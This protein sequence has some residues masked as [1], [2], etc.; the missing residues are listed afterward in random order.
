MKKRNNT[1]KGIWPE[2][3]GEPL[4]TAPQLMTSQ[5]LL[6]TQLRAFSNTQALV[7]P[8]ESVSTVA[9]PSWAP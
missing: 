2:V 1:R 3:G 4:K 7:W 8:P 9:G 6:V 5:G